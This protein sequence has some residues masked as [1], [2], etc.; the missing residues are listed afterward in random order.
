MK[1]VTTIAYFP[2]PKETWEK[3]DPQMY[4]DDG[5]IILIP[6]PGKAKG[7]LIASYKKGTK[8]RQKTSSRFCKEFGEYHEGVWEMVYVYKEKNTDK[9]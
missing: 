6:E 2:T 7:G 8:E 3:K 5:G 9:V 1:N 4:L